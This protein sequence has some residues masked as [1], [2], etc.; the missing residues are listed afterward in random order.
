MMAGPQPIN[1]RSLGALAKKLAVLWGGPTFFSTFRKT[2]AAFR[3]KILL[4]V[5]MANACGG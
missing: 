5:S 1:V 3:E 2:G 4:T